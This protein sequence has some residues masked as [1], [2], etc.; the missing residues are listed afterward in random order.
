[1]LVFYGLLSDDCY[2]YTVDAIPVMDASHI[3]GRLA[4]F[5][6][7]VASCHLLV[8]ARLQVIQRTVSPSDVS[9]IMTCDDMCRLWFDLQTSN[10][11]SSVFRCPKVMAL[12]VNPYMGV[13]LLV[14]FRLLSD[15]L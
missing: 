7:C 1:M 9:Y 12:V 3:H 15:G 8:L 6:F 14:S 2:V 4:L 11:S 5:R 13:P 10:V